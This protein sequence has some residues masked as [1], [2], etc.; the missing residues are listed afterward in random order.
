M[1]D[2][3]FEYQIRLMDSWILVVGLEE[4]NGRYST[5][6]G[7]RQNVR[8]N[9]RVRSS[10]CN[11][12]CQLSGRITCIRNRVCDRR[13]YDS[14]IVDSVS[15]TDRRFTVIGCRIRKAYTWSK[16][17]FVRWQYEGLGN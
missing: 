2:F 10:L 7:R 12:Q 8:E 15:A 14:A 5:R 1:S 17:I 11:A 16:I 9:D 4:L 13:I 3:T 6:C